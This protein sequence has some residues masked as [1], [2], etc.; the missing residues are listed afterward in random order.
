MKAL[1]KLLTALGAVACVL[2]VGLAVAQ[3]DFYA[4]ERHAIGALKT[5]MTS[6]AVFREGDK[7]V[8]G[9]LDYGML[10]ELS[11]TTLVDAVLGSGTKQG[12]LFEASYSYA[13]SEFLWWATA[14]PE[15]P[16]ET[17]ERYFFTNQA[18]VIYESTK[19]F[20][21]NKVTCEPPKDAKP[22]GAM[23]APRDSLCRELGSVA[24]ADGMNAAHAFDAVQEGE[25]YVLEGNGRETVTIVS[26]TDKAVKYKIEGENGTKDE[27][28]SLK[29]SRSRFESDSGPAR[30]KPR[31][32]LRD[33]VFVVSAVAIPC[34]VEEIEEAGS[35]AT[36]WTCP[37]RFP[38][39]LKM[40]DGSGRTVFEL[41]QIQNAKPTLPT[42][43]ACGAAFDP[44][45]RFCAK[46]GKPRP[47]IAP[48][49]TCPGCG[50][51]F[52]PD[53]KFCVNCGKP[54]PD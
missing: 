11:N 19:P 2:A 27:V 42:T 29:P 35:K 7:E 30:K 9:N 6:E 45:D 17:G 36:L 24:N 1:L 53:A 41:K 51:P 33:D 50:T 54:K 23:P 26:K 28:F 16:G 49:T 39:L 40:T 48:K 46:C 22:V 44:E 14:S 47:G 18:G 4:N 52:K 31:K 43:C 12:Y 32:K 37:D 5:I 10:S 21:F 34:V 38:F 8:D 3:D 25:V 15:K 13:T 20:E